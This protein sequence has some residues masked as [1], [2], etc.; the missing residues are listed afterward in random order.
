MA[1]PTDAHFNGEHTPYDAAIEKHDDEGHAHQ[2]GVLSDDPAQEEECGKRVYHTTE[3]DVISRCT[4]GPE[5]QPAARPAP[6][7][8]FRADATVEVEEHDTQG[9]KGHGVPPDVTPATMEEGHTE[10][11]DQ[12]T[13]LQRAV[14]ISVEPEVELEVDE[15]DPPNE[16]KATDGEDKGVVDP[17][18]IRLQFFRRW[19]PPG[20]RRGR[21]PMG[22]P[23]S[24]A[25]RDADL[26]RVGGC[27]AVGR[28]RPTFS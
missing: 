16:H 5:Q 11:A 23:R 25:G 7:Q 28:R 15:E 20:V 13:D 21:S 10:Y 3:P 17:S 22:A 1:F 26:I 8:H 24:G 2:Y 18:P 6:E 19:G 12:P 9:E 4:T 14:S 27:A